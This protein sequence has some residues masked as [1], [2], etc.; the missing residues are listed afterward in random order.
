MSAISQWGCVYGAGCCWSSLKSIP[1]II[2][3][4]WALHQ[5]N[6]MVLFIGFQRFKIYRYFP[7]DAFFL[8]LLENLNH[9]GDPCL[10]SLAE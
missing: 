9:L 5:K 10:R 3:T 1:L 6:N 2:L 4:P 8:L 7:F